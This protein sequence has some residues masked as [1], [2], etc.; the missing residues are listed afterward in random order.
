MNSR[1][2]LARAFLVWVV[3]HTSIT[4]ATSHEIE[5]VS[6]TNVVQ[7]TPVSHFIAPVPSPVDKDKI[8]FTREQ[9]Q[10]LFVLSIATGQVS[11]IA[12]DDGSGFKFVWANDGRHI[13]YRRYVGPGNTV[14]RVVDVESR[15]VV[16]LSP[17][18][19]IGLPQE[20]APGSFAYREAGQGRRAR[21]RTDGA[22][23]GASR[24]FVYQEGDQILVE[25]D[26]GIVRLTDGSGKNYLPLLSPDGKKVVYEEL[27]TGIHVTTI[28]KGRAARIGTGNSPRWSPDSRFIVFEVPVDD[29]HTIVSSELRMVSYPD[30]RIIRLTGDLPALPRRPSFTPDGNHIVF[31]AG[32]GIFS[33]EVTL[34]SG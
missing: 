33:A 9:Y 10:G 21:F 14:N 31:D 16:D 13:A 19:D 27:S 28:E 11:Q 20:V 32:G 22:G 23:E 29:G 24:P 5:A 12:I 8:A 6:L 30:L 26:G 34:P 3:L 18:G 1:L 17:I 7:L 2:L 15:Q 4:S 25:I